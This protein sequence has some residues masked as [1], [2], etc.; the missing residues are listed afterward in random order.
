MTAKPLFVAGVTV[1]ALLGALT[2]PGLLGGSPMDPVAPVELR[3]EE[4]DDRPI[5][6]ERGDRDRQR[7]R[8]AARPR[9]APGRKRGYR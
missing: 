3:A 7:K 5:P 6:R 9:A 8:V 1:L 4:S 2:A